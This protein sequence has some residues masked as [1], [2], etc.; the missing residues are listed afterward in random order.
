MGI[1]KGFEYFVT[2]LQIPFVLHVTI[3]FGVL[4]AFATFQ[5]IHAKAKKPLTF[6][7]IIKLPIVKILTYYLIAWISLSIA[8]F[9]I[10][11]AEPCLTGGSGRACQEFGIFGGID[12]ARSLFLF[13]YQITTITFLELPLLATLVKSKTL[14]NRVVLLNIFLVTFILLII[15]GFLL[16]EFTTTIQGLILRTFIPGA[17]IKFFW[18]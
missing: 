4:V 14:P 18:N 17:H 5:I 11:Q 9:F 8:M 3:F 13:A 1:A 15:T 2:S 10:Y 7:E 16:P 12:H 6:T